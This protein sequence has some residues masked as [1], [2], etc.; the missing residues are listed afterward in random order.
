MNNKVFIDTSFVVALSVET[1]NYHA[2]A[3][4][5]AEYIAKNKY[6]MVTHQGI[7]LEIGNIF[8][9]PP[10]RKTASELIAFLQHDPTIKIVSISTLLLSEAIQLFSSQHEKSW[11]M[12][13]CLSFIVMR[14]SNLETALTANQHFAEAGFR[15]LL[16]E[17]PTS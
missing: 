1:D 9:K 7:L 13:D 4:S 10:W 14:R 12:T 16:K 11:R 5:W 8:S 3:K 2:S 17:E 6:H 15:T